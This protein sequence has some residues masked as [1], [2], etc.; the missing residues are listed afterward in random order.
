LSRIDRELSQRVQ[1]T[2]NRTPTGAR[3][4][5]GGCIGEVL[6]LDFDDGGAPVV[7]KIARQGGLEPEGYMLEVLNARSELPV[8][9][10]LSSDDTLLLMTYIDGNGGLG[11]EAQRDAAEH[12]AKLHAVRGPHFGL[13]RDTL[14]GPLHQPNPQSDRWIAFF[15]DHRLRYM[16]DVAKDRGRLGAKQRDKIERFAGKL[17]QYLE[18]PSHPA[19]LH[20][21]LWG[22]NVLTKGNRIAGFIDPAVYYGHPEIELAFSTL[23]GTFGRPFFERYAELAELRPGFFEARRDIYNIYPLLVH[24]AAF[25]GGWGDQAIATVERFL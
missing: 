1:D 14:I 7:A 16:A 24:A 9:E 15:R 20:G 17:E 21:D 2:L 10:V 12:V 4:L 19:L 25:G 11:A 18:E 22:G 5:P 6:R 13:E 8:P 23:F 3:P